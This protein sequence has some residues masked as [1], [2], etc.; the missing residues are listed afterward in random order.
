MTIDT[1]DYERNASETTPLL[2]T[3]AKALSSKERLAAKWQIVTLCWSFY[4]VGWG[5]G[6]VG[7]LIPPIQAEYGVDFSQ[8]SY[9]F[10]AGCI[11][12][13]QY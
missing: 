6:T 7:P 4:L 11:V 13:E 12:S 1:Q 3:P 10:I 5:D 9:I 2:A 8:V